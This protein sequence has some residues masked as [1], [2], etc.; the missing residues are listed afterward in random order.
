MMRKKKSKV[1]KSKLVAA[2]YKQLT[3]W[4][5]RK[6]IMYAEWG[7]PAPPVVTMGRLSKGL[8]AMYA[9]EAIRTK[10]TK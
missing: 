5:E 1:M 7:L 10:K 2:W 4:H 6:L 9:K 8:I 3:G